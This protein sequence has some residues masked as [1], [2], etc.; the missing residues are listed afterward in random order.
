[1]IELPHTIPAELTHY[2]SEEILPCYARFDKAHQT[3]H[4]QKVISES[5]TLA[6]N[7]DVDNSMVYVIA[8]YHDLGLSNGREFHHLDSGKILM[9]DTELLKWFTEEQLFIM[10]EAIEDHRASNKHE[11]RSI[12]GKIVAEAD[13][14]IDKDVT[15]RRTVQ[16]GLSHYPELDKEE[17]FERF[18]NHIIHKYGKE[19]YLKLWIEES[20][21]GKQLREFRELIEKPEEMRCIF[22]KIYAE[23]HK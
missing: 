9:T 22:E 17:Q 13:R 20:T 14:I 10:K 1:M 4:A 7:Y 21:N 8:A 23:E 2:I 11:P 15:T 18:M 16:F 12:Y 6:Q 5:L 19:G 3:D